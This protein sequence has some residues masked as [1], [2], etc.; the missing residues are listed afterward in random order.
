ML[1]TN[2]LYM[3]ENTQTN[4]GFENLGIAEKILASVKNAGLTE[5]TPIQR[6]SI[7]TA[8]QGKDLV[9][10]AQTG[11]GKTLAYSIPMIQR[12]ALYKGRGL[13][14]VPT[15]ELAL[16]VNENFKKFSTGMGIRTVVLIGGENIGR[17]MKEL[18]QL[19]NIIIATPGRL[20]DH[21]NRHT[22]KLTDV[23]ILVLDEADLML[24]MGFLPQ[25]DAVLKNVP[26]E[27]QTMLFSATMPPAIVQ[28]LRMYMT[29]PVRVE[30][31]P[32]GTTAAGI[33][34]E[35]FIVQRAGKL[36]QLEILL[37][38]YT[39]SVLVFCRTKYGVKD[40]T[41]KVELM[42]H[43]VAE[44]HSNRSQAQRRVALDGFRSG[45]I[46]V[47]VATDIAARGIDVKNISLVLN[48]DLPDEI[49]D[50]IHRIGR[51]ARAGKTGKAISFADPGQAK[52]I[53]EIERLV[54][55][56]LPLKELTPLERIPER[57]YS[58]HSRGRGGSGRNFNRG[59]SPGRR[60][61][62]S[63]ASSSSGHHFNKL[64]KFGGKKK[65]SGRDEK[66]FGNRT[67][68]K[69]GDRREKQFGD[70]RGPKSTFIPVTERIFEKTSRR[71][72]IERQDN[73]RRFGGPPRRRGGGQRGGP[74]RQE[75]SRR[76]KDARRGDSADI[77]E[78]PRRQ[79]SGGRYDSASRDEDKGHRSFGSTGKR[80]EYGRKR[81]EGSRGRHKKFE[82][83]PSNFGDS[84]RSETARGFNA[85]RRS[86]GGRD[87][88]GGASR[89]DG[90]V[91][92]PRY[93]GGGRRRFGNT[94][95]RNEGGGAKRFGGKPGKF[96]S[97]PNSGFG[98]FAKRK[99]RPGFKSKKF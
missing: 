39:G 95:R 40:L 73:E 85:P 75:G 14:L 32:P 4:S 70:S 97:K 67:E 71:G 50:Y 57:G 88:F 1:A 31:A 99:S 98:G 69:F 24:D 12:L 59:G 83:A 38:E 20:N 30:V 84:R 94:D 80:E 35:I 5:P 56:T 33:D 29:E 79:E 45:K 17:Q 3:S 65:F 18:R 25:I 16:Q 22:I 90:A 74:E 51:T 36:A 78:T 76:F 87:R 54:K 77:F 6:K 15:R 52:E 49:N 91:E 10:I 72:G 86:E 93:Q 58:S 47:L 96:G 46:R 55:K 63:G 53:R 42:G 44:I 2:P 8:I 82:S 43:A 27:R 19:P 34:Q 64:G 13:V 61:E 7:P 62:R 66:S 21:L 68:K 28:L 37:R 23:K 60:F 26:Q 9:G 92:T 81:F 89:G 41:R 11:T 48:Y